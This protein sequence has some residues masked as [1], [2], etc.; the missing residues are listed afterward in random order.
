MLV[1]V[2][3]DEIIRIGDNVTLTADPFGELSQVYDVG[4]H[5][6][7][8]MGN[9]GVA[10]SK[11]DFKKD[12]SLNLRTTLEKSEIN[13]Y[14]N[15]IHYKGD[16]IYNFIESIDKGLIKLTDNTIIPLQD[17]SCAMNCYNFNVGDKVYISHYALENYTMFGGFTSANGKVYRFPTNTGQKIDIK[18][19]D[20]TKYW[21]NATIEQVN[22]R[23]EYNYTISFD[24][25][26][27]KVVINI[28]GW[29][30]LIHTPKKVKI[31][32][33]KNDK[34][35]IKSTSKE[36]F[37]SKVIKTS[38]KIYYVITS[39]EDKKTLTSKDIKLIERV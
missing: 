2:F 24:V 1:N 33:K 5:T 22:D 3:T 19:S 37:V 15:S 30:L 11:H 4:T 23:D 32:F 6:L 34:V 29:D 25:L 27:Q 36:G 28:E 39:G 35:I 17:C 9:E 20:L 12:V 16:S 26:G 8:L 10:H 31:D 21:I 18:E 14:F 38:G 13:K 7:V